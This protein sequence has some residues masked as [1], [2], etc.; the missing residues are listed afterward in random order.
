MRKFE[1]GDVV[2]FTGYKD[3]K[4][5]ITREQAEVYGLIVSAD[6]AI[7]TRVQK[8]E[9]DRTKKEIEETAKLKVDKWD[10]L[11]VWKSSETLMWTPGI[12]YIFQTTSWMTHEKIEGEQKQ[13]LMREMLLEANG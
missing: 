1:Y 12:A 11:I 6:D 7:A 5:S 13:R 8:G 2:K 4:S 10:W 3:H 9:D